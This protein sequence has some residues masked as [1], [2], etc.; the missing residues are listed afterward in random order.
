MQRTVLILLLMLQALGKAYGQSVVLPIAPVGQQ[1]SQWCW[2]SCAEMIFKYH[3]I[4]SINPVGN[5]QCGIIAL[6]GPVCSGNCMACPVPA[7]STATVQAML[8]QYPLR[9][10]AVCG[11]Q[12]KSVFSQDVLA[13]LSMEQVIA[14]VND[15]R[16]IWT[17]INPSGYAT[18]PESAHA[19]L[20]VGYSVE[21]GVPYL[22]V[23]D[24][25]PYYSAPGPNPYLANGGFQTQPFQYKISYLAYRSGLAW[26]RTLANIQF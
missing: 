26:N 21:G 2:V 24:P 23:N 13:P 18:G 11:S 6:L 22:I 20:I 3:G 19:T 10:A 1:T 14:Q 12:P 9:A 7:G 15:Q 5:Y 8:A 17:G 16:P 25:F 4:C